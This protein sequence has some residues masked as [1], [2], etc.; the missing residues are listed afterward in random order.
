MSWKFIIF[1]VIFA[2]VT[3]NS[4]VYSFLVGILSATNEDSID[5]IK[6]VTSF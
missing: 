2:P 5:N 4:Q 1:S 3:A 6:T